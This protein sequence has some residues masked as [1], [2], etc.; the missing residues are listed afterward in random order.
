MNDTLR[1]RKSFQPVG[2]KTFARGLK[3]VN[4]SMVLVGNP[5]R[6]IYIQTTTPSVAGGASKEITPIVGSSG[7][8]PSS[9]YSSR[10]SPAWLTLSWLT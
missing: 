4:A 5:E 10:I 3:D 8:R 9:S 2:W 7:R 6:W 1:K